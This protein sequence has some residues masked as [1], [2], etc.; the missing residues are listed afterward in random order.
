MGIDRTEVAVL[1]GGCFWC[2][3]AIFSEIRGVSKVEPG[4]SG[5]DLPDPTYEEVCTGRTGHAETVRISYD[6][7]V[8]SYTD[9]LE[10]FFSTHDPTTLNRQGNDVGTQYRS[11][12]FY[13]N[14]DQ[15]REAADMI[16]K[17]EAE[18]RFKKPI[19]TKVEKFENFYPAEE[20]HRD[21]FRNNPDSPYCMFV[22][23]PKIAKFRKSFAPVLRR[24]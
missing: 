7:D 12:I 5:G 16:R 11:V 18:G 4:Y 8:I 20:Y 3:E 23:E 19:V 2:L 13:T 6:P 22:I 1:A 14:T 9:I 10:I 15:E 17:L 21:Y 24:D